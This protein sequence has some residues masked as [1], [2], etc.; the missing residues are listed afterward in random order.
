MNIQK[1]AFGELSNGEK[2][3]KFV[4]GNN[5][6]LRICAIDYGAI[7]TSVVF[8]DRRGEPGEITLG[9]DSIEKYEGDNPYFGATIGR[10]A[11]RIS[12]GGF[13]LAEQRYNLAGNEAGVHLHGGE[14]GFNRKMWSAEVE[15][16]TE[17]GTITFSR[18]SPDK[19]EN[20][21]GSLNVSVSFILT[22][23]NELYFE[24][25][26]TTDK[27]TPV[28]MTNH[29]YWNL[30]GPGNPVYDHLLTVNADKYL[31]VDEKLIPTGNLIDLKG[32]P[33][34]FKNEKP[35]GKDLEKVDGY[36]HCLAL[37][38]AEKGMRKAATLKDPLTGRCMSIDTNQPA[39]QFYTSN[40]LEDTTGRRG[41]TFR[42]RG[43]VCLE[44]GGYINAVNIPSFPNSVLKPGDIYRHIT[45]HS[46]WTE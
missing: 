18:I 22:E 16:E 20:Y 32:T 1:E 6:G 37:V 25:S 35:I 29:T 41:V 21:P 45:R 42:R 26:A 2:V 36:D 24:Y 13:T 4:I 9:F 23:N 44:T 10:Y 33:L 46:F 19:E 11:N 38:D 31:E 15:A 8:T 28:N 12:D 34:D 30:A 40:M 7:L 27:Y 17:K 3:T 39:I 5:S 14:S 43:A